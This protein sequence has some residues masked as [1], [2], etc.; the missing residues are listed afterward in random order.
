MTPKSNSR[1]SVTTIDTSSEPAHPS[2][3]KKKTNIALGG[4]SPVGQ[5]PKSCGT[6]RTSS[7][8][9]ARLRRSIKLERSDRTGRLLALHCKAQRRWVNPFRRTSTGESCLPVPLANP[10][11]AILSSVVKSPTF[12]PKRP[13]SFAALARSLDRNL[14][15]LD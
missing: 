6:R 1:I 2:L 8:T 4:S 11:R 10:S 3:F 13:T 15:R 14:T 5:A 12:S 7:Q 9:G